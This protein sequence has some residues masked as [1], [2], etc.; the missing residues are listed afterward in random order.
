MNKTRRFPAALGLGIAALLVVASA[1]GAGYLAARDGN[2]DTATLAGSDEPTATAEAL[3]PTPGEEDAEGQATSNGQQLIYSLFGQSADSLMSFD[4]DSGETAELLSVPHA[5]NYGITGSV[6]ANGVI[7]YLSLPTNLGGP[8]A[9]LLASSSAELW[10][11]N[12]GSPE[13]LAGGFD[14]RGVPEWSPDGEQLAVQSIEYSTETSEAP[15]K[16]E[17][18]DLEG[19]IETL[20]DRDAVLALEVIGYSRDGDRL[21]FAETLPGGTTVIQEANLASGSVSEITR[22]DDYIEFV[23]WT[24]GE[25]EIAAMVVDTS[26]EGEPERR[27]VTVGIGESNRGVR[28]A[29]A[30]ESEET[31]SPAWLDGELSFGRA[32]EGAIAGILILRAGGLS[33][34]TDAAGVLEIP[35]F[36]SGDGSLLAGLRFSSFPPTMPGRPF[37]LLPNGERIDVPISGEV[38]LLGWR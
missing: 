35:E 11:L 22:G 19:S 36:W 18:V 2:D 27:V 16:I 17:L 20:V 24:V 6:S 13:Q 33:Q 37:V 38:T 25:D 3:T 5:E 12:G 31:L 34:L 4:P 26:A 9:N 8:Q 23:S 14:L 28:G 10:T 15:A 21:Y 32:P 29:V 30:A 7:A 1:L